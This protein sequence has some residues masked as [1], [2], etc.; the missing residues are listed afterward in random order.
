MRKL[1]VSLTAEIRRAAVS[2]AKPVDAK[3]VYKARTGIVVPLSPD[4]RKFGH[5]AEPRVPDRDPFISIVLLSNARH[6]PSPTASG[7]ADAVED[8]AERVLKKQ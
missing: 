8:A 1:S 5:I 3:R 6:L 4:Y 2:P 7:K